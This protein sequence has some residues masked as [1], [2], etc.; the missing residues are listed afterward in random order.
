[1]SPQNAQFEAIADHYEHSLPAHVVAHYLQKR[2]HFLRLCVGERPAHV[3]DV[4]AGTGQLAAQLVSSTW[5]VFA[6]DAAQAMLSLA[7]RRELPAVRST[8]VW[9]PFADDTFDLVYCVAVLH[10]IAEPAAVRATVREMWRVVRP[11]GVAVYWDHNP[12]NPYWPIIMARVPQDTGEERLIPAR[13]IRSALAGLPAILTTY[14]SGFVGDFVPVQWLG[15]FQKL[16]RIIEA[17]PGI[18]RIAC[19]HNVIVARKPGR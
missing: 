17:L 7:V 18:R 15:A 2:A 5:R 3:L 9:L 4:G 8:G 10:H 14:S 6:L 1:M 19:A 11:G 13:E 16:E 12:L